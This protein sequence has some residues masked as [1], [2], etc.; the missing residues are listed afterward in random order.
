M[1]PREPRVGA[2]KRAPKVKPRT[3]R[4]AR[5]HEA[6]QTCGAHAVAIGAGHTVV[7]RQPVHVSSQRRKADRTIRHQITAQVRPSCHEFGRMLISRPRF[8]TGCRGGGRR[9][10]PAGGPAC[11]TTP[12]LRTVRKPTHKTGCGQRYAGDKE[13]SITSISYY[14]ILL[15][16]ANLDTL[17]L[18]PYTHGY[19]T[20]NTCMFGVEFSIWGQN[21]SSSNSTRRARVICAAWR[22][23]SYSS[24]PA[25]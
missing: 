13:I 14:L 2:A 3:L 1:Q 17:I 20:R 15:L 5:A 25:K 22:R 23:R 12:I 8:W 10:P 4:I 24:K 21:G 18:R 11:R 6:S 16:Y 7:R 9:V 19:A